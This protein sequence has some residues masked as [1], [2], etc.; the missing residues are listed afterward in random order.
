[1]NSVIV[2]LN[3]KYEGKVR[4][5]DMEIPCHV[6]VKKLT[7]HIAL[8]LNGYSRR[9][10]L[11]LSGGSLYSHRLERQLQGSETFDQ[12]GIWNGDYLDFKF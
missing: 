6:P 7:E 3:F 10:Q 11:P 2:T 8:T 1:M 5:Y 12:A 4:G 9:Y